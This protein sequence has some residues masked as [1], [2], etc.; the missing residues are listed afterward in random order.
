MKRN[1]PCDPPLTDADLRR[2]NETGAL[3]PIRV[4]SPAEQQ[5]FRSAVEE[6]EGLFGPNAQRSVFGQ[7]HLSFKWAYDLCTHIRVLDAVEQIIG[8]D[9][10]VHSSTL[11]SKHPSESFVSWHQDSFYWHL[12]RPQL[13]SAWISLSDSTVEN[14]CM[15][16]QLGTHLSVLDHTENRRPD[17]MLGTGST[18]K[19]SFDESCA[20]DVVLRAGEMSLHHAHLVHGSNPN[21]S[22][23]K[24]VGFVVRYVAP[25]VRQRRGHHQVVL[26]RGQDRYQHFETLREPPMHSVTAGLLIHVAFAEQLGRRKLDE[27][28]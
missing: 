1:S 22:N 14:G 6:L 16:F 8:P 12:S 3:F 2:Y 20:V 26:A 28:G 17:N 15:R 25:E 4:L 7:C 10:L 21:R 11:F 24:R 9:I 13:V 27:L 19:T 5:S 23:A 18:V